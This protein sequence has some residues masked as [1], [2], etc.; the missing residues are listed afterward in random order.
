MTYEKTELRDFV[1]DTNSMALINTNVEAMK[2]YKQRRA[3]RRDAKKQNDTILALEKE[4]DDLKQLVY[5]L[6]EEKNG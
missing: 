6:L 3:E 1:R 4:V 2:L 5:K